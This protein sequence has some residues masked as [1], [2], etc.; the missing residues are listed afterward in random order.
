LRMFL[1][2]ISPA[3]VFVVATRHPCAR[4]VRTGA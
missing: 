1:L 2:S 4:N 3:G